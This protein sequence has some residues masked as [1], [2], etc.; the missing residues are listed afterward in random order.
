M[1]TITAKD[2]AYFAD[3]HHEVRTFQETGRMLNP[4]GQATQMVETWLD[5]LQRYGLRSVMADAEELRNKAAAYDKNPR[6]K[7]LLP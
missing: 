4:N 2:I 6:P 3:V 7:I 1:T 5:L